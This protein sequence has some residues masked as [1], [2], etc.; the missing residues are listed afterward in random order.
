MSKISEAEVSRYHFIR[1]KSGSMQRLVRIGGNDVEEQN[2]ETENEH[3]EAGK[4]S[5]MKIPNPTKPSKDEVDEHNMTHMPYRS[6]CRHCVRGRGKEWPHRR[7]GGEEEGKQNEIH[8]DF[9][10]MGKENE[11]GKTLPILVAKQKSTKML[12]AAA[13]LRKTTGRYIVRR[14]MAFLRETGCEFGDLTVKSDNEE[15]IKAVVDGLARERAARGGG[16]TVVENSPVG[17][18]ASN[19]VVERD[20]QSVQGQGRVILDALEERWLKRI[21]YDHPVVCYVVEHAAFLLNRFEVGRDGLTS[22]ERCKGKKAKT[23]GIEFGEAVHWKKKFAGGALVKLSVSWEDGVYLGVKGSSGEV[24]VSNTRGIWKTRSVQRKPADERWA[25]ESEKMVTFVPWRVSS[26]DP[27]ADGEV[28]RV[29]DAVEMSPGEV[30][31][32]E[33]RE[34]IP[35]RFNITKEDLT[36]HG[37]S[38]ACPGC[39]ALLRGLARQGHSEGCRK[40]LEK[41]MKEESKVKVTKKKLEEITKTAVELEE[42]KRKKSRSD[43]R[44]VGSGPVGPG[45]ASSSSQIGPDRSGAES[46]V[47]GKADKQELTWP[48]TRRKEREMMPM[49]KETK[50]DQVEIWICPRCLLPAW[51]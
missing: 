2:E 20:I 23:I 48:R 32:E 35:R 42:E 26:E 13:M 49:E 22:F 51:S 8:L 14:L 10:S 31:G 44:A 24:I 36:K 29:P 46:S 34:S 5:T 15:A 27:E 38:V 9:C 30:A 6:W 4:R 39:S 11:P 19:G 3:V 33:L 18:S 1:P 47:L 37:Y 45:A 41:E 25:A 17:A 12:M 21:P 50:S 28:V 16:R 7:R 43:P 40:R